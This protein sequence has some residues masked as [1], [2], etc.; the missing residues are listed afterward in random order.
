[1]A[2]PTT[3]SILGGNRPLGATAKS[4]FS[5]ATSMVNTAKG[6][7]EQQRTVQPST[8]RPNNVLAGSGPGSNTLG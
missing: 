5:P 7:Q 2:K 3:E 6:L 1:M 8:L 4:A